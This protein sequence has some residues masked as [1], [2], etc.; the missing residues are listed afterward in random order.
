MFIT[1]PLV[2]F[3]GRERKVIVMTSYSLST[4]ERKRTKEDILA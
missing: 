3:F 4:A 2:S 1:L